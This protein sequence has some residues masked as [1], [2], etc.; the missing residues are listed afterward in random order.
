MHKFERPVTMLKKQTHTINPENEAILVRYIGKTETFLA[1][2]NG[3]TRAP[4]QRIWD[5]APSEKNLR[6]ASMLISHQGVLLKD[7]E[8]RNVEVMFEIRAISYC[9]AELPPHGRVF[10][11]VARRP[12]SPLL[13]CYAVLCPSAD[14]AQAAAV[15]LSR[16]FQYAHQVDTNIGSNPK[17]GDI[18]PMFTPPRQ[19]DIIPMFNGKG[20]VVIDRDSGLTSSDLT[21][22]DSLD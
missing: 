13:H 20:S 4:V 6:R 10:A 18:I 9:A 3:C 7:L 14:K 16:A 12:S 22:W 8:Q 2:G 17:T 21:R 5:N 15:Q 1:T 19:T 11:W